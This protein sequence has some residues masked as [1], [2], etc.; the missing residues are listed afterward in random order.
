[1][2]T[3]FFGRE[4]MSEEFRQYMAK[5]MMVQ[6]SSE[7]SI[8]RLFTTITCPEIDYFQELAETA[9]GES[10]HSRG[11]ARALQ[12][13]GYDPEPI[14]ESARFGKAEKMLDILRDP[15]PRDYDEVNVLRWLSERAGG[16][17]SITLFGCRYIPYACFA[18]QNYMDEGEGHPDNAKNMLKDSIAQGRKARVQEYLDTIYPMAL[19][20][21]GRGGSKNE[22]NYLN[23]GIK[24][25]P[26]DVTRVMW[27][28][29]TLEN[30]HELGLRP[31][32]DLYQGLRGH[33]GECQELVESFRDEDMPVV[34]N[35]D[36][37][38]YKSPRYRELL[39]REMLRE[40]VAGL[41]YLENEKHWKRL[42][43][44]DRFQDL[45]MERQKEAR[46][47]DSL[48]REVE[49]TGYC[50]SEALWQQVI[51]EAEANP[52]LSLYEDI[53]EGDDLEFTV[54]HHLHNRFRGV[55]AIRAFGSN[56]VRYAV[57]S[58]R[59]YFLH[60]LA[61]WPDVWRTDDLER[62]G[63]FDR[64]AVDAAFDRWLPR[65]EAAFEASAD[66]AE[67]LEYGIV[68]KPVADVRELFTDSIARDRAQLVGAQA[69]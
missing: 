28:R 24:Q 10:M 25:I 33:Y 50:S 58:F 32:A 42:F 14:I 66:E 3:L 62:M 17:Q 36:G 22:Q 44:P 26:N 41:R 45:L 13:L 43:G 23:L 51:G 2:N 46:L 19:D 37:L 59:A 11:I 7:N 48:R 63:T 27:I 68:D 57:A 4:G 61:D 12:E 30:I 64:G 5:V 9:A 54:Y 18:A 40:A 52:L 55:R 47:M 60:V 39:G 53:P 29:K 6:L 31:P 15:R 69:A 16:F 38:S 49:A 8:V 56:Y 1:M 35:S 67:L 34:L 65:F 21:F 20:M